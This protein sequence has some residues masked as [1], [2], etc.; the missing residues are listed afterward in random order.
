MS[1]CSII[2]F[3]TNAKTL[4]KSGQLFQPSESTKSRLTKLVLLRPKIHQKLKFFTPKAKTE[5]SQHFNFL[6]VKSHKNM[7]FRTRG[8]KFKRR[9]FHTFW[10][11]NALY[12]VGLDF[13]PLE[14]QKNGLM[15]GCTK[16]PPSRIWHNFCSLAFLQKQC[17]SS[18]WSSSLFRDSKQMQNSW[19]MLKAS[20]SVPN[21]SHETV[22]L[23]KKLSP[24]QF[25]LRLA[26]TSAWPKFRF[27]P[28]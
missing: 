12:V 27:Q 2:L 9:L 14:A 21:L 10:S 18:T 15:C 8:F 26:G 16:G 25:L 23:E 28:N 17:H 1:N 13:D 4:I 5:Q 7:N 22:T 24:W 11:V 20:C 19:W 6:P 3:S